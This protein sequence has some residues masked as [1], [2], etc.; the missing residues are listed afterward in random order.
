VDANDIFTVCWT[1]GT[2]ADSK[3]IPRSQNHWMAPA[4]APLDGARLPRGCT[5]LCLFPMVNLS[6]IGAMMTVWILTGSKMAL[7]HPFN[8]PVYLRRSPWRK[9]SSPSPRPSC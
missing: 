9:P 4:C 3:G 2:E 1:S 8:L 7:H 6:G 5:V